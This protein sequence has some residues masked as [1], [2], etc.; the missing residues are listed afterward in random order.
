M[1]GAKSEEAKNFAV[2]FYK[3]AVQDIIATLKPRK[4]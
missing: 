2:S 3:E 4:K 1:I